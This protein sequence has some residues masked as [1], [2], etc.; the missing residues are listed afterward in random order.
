MNKVI[1]AVGLLKY[2]IERVNDE[3]RSLYLHRD[4]GEHEFLGTWHIDDFEQAAARIYQ[5]HIG[6]GNLHYSGGIDRAW[7]R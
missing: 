7:M 2:V 5:R 4:N 1:L 6:M 3:M